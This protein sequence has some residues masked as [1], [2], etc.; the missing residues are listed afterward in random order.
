MYKIIVSKDVYKELRRFPARQQR[1]FLE[2]IDSLK[3]IP[4]PVGCKKLVDRDGVYR[5]RVGDYRL[6]YRVDQKV[7]TILVL[8]IV[9]RREIYRF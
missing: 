2:V 1:L 5:I 9:H 4:F 6:L 8:R 7:L 3:T